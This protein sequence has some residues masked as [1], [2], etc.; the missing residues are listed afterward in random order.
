[1]KAGE[2]KKRFGSGEMIGVEEKVL[3][4]KWQERRRSHSWELQ[5]SRNK[6]AGP[7]C[8]G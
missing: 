5:N 4:G 8:N 2:H 7:P 3:G 1:M 6:E